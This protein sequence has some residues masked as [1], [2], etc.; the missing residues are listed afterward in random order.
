MAALERNIAAQRR[1]RLGKLSSPRLAYSKALEYRARLFGPTVKTTR[2]FFGSPM[3][4]IFPDRVSASI[5]RYGFFEAEL[6]RAIVAL[7]R[8]GM[9]FFDVGAHI[10]YFSLLARWCV[11]RTGAVHAF[12]P[13]PSTYRLLVENVGGQAHLND[14]A[15]LDGEADIELSDFGWEFSA[16]NSVVDDR[17]VGKRHA[18]V[19][20]ERVVVRTLSLDAYS[21]QTGVRPDVIKVDAEGA[22]AR[23]LRGAERL[24]ADVR[25]V[26][27]LEVGKRD[28]SRE[29]IEFLERRGYTPFEVRDNGE[30][31]THEVRDV[32][33]YDNLIFLPAA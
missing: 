23:I 2:T 1:R 6:T 28:P 27:T 5:Y 22:E 4:V 32:Y 26:M 13:T 10:G 17:L 12:E 25:P 7:L 11:G 9:V 14:I 16:F 29:N 15:V 21:E 3:R 8:P 31:V 24:L 18:T 19:P 33:R 20:R 30:L